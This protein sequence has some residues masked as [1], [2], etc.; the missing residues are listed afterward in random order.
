MYD[1]D[2]IDTQNQSVTDNLVDK[3]RALGI[4]VLRAA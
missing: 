1:I 2:T 3:A 4:P